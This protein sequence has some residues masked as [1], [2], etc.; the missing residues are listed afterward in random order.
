MQRLQ[1]P[2]V[3]AMADAIDMGAEYLY[4]P[5]YSDAGVLELCIHS[6]YGNKFEI[7]SFS[8]NGSSYSGTLR[9]TLYDHFGL[10]TLK[11]C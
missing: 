9:F 2:M 10:D 1:H 5:Y 11:I 4:E 6:L 8:L 7:E 3:N